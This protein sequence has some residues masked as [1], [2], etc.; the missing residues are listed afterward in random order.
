MIDS[1]TRV[2]LWLGALSFLVCMVAYSARGYVADSAV[3][4]VLACVSFWIATTPDQPH[5]TDEE[6]AP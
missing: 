2:M 3:Y 5:T 1:G 4:A 6:H